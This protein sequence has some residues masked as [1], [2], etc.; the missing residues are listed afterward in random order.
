MAEIVREMTREEL[1][2]ANNELRS[3]NE[4]LKKELVYWH[5]LCQS[6]ESTIVKLSVAACGFQKAMLAYTDE[7]LERIERKMKEYHSGDEYD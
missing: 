4:G 5:D 6:Y 2:Y 1:V 7:E 3:E